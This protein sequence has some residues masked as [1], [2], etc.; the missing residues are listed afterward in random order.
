MSI[1]PFWISADI[2]G[3]KSQ[4]SGGTS[5]KNGWNVVYL[6]QRDKGEITNPYKVKQFTEED[7]NGVLKCYT[8][9]YYMDEF[10]HE[11]VTEY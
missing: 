3:R 9:I 10:I 1:R 2:K 7:E 5:D 8:Q 11:H 6:S 4:L